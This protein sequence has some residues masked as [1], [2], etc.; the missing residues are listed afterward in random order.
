MEFSTTLTDNDVAA[1]MMVDR[2]TF[3]A[4]ADLIPEIANRWRWNRLLF[5]VPWV[6]SPNGLRQRCR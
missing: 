1:E 2:R 4:Q 3:N 6:L 5:C